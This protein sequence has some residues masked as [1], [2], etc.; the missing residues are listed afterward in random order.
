MKKI[1]ISETFE[2]NAYY[3]WPINRNRYTAANIAAAWPWSPPGSDSWHYRFESSVRD[4]YMCILSIS[5]TNAQ[6]WDLQRDLHKFLLSSGGVLHI[7]YCTY[8]RYMHKVLL[9]DARYLVLCMA[10][11]SDDHDKALNLCIGC[12]CIYYART[13][14]GCARALSSSSSSLFIYVYRGRILHV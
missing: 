12:T 6:P 2:H 7:I 14:H 10:S 11:G 5:F 1:Y 9:V 13:L 8:D 4:I 3:V